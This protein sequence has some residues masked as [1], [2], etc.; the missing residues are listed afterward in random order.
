MIKVQQA[1]E[2]IE[3]VQTLAELTDTVLGQVV[4]EQFAATAATATPKIV[5]DKILSDYN[6]A[7]TKEFIRVV[8]EVVKS[9]DS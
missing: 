5:Q 1:L 3:N 8:R 2:N 9:T 4:I 7:L 6:G